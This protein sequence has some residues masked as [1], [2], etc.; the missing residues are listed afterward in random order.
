MGSI[1]TV[2]GHQSRI[3]CII[4]SFPA[5]SKV[6]WKIETSTLSAVYTENGSVPAPFSLTGGTLQSPTLEIPRA[7]LD[8][9]GI[10]TCIGS[11][12]MG[13]TESSQVTFNVYG[14]KF[15]KIITIC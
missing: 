10:Y 13:V 11:N 2:V 6:E 12:A 9:T 4:E 5:L 3:V 1:Q 15:Y 8:M 7:S 14:G